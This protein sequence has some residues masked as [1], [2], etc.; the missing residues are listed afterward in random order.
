MCKVDLVTLNQA[1]GRF[2]RICVEIDIS[3][4]LV[5]T[6]NVEERSIKMEYENLGAICFNC[7]HYGHSKDSCKEGLVEPIIE[8]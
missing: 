8:E 7:G 5:A 6:L 3:K 1:R 4:P 2:A